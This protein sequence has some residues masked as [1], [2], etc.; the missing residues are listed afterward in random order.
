MEITS[1]LQSMAVSKQP[2]HL[3]SSMHVD[4]IFPASPERRRLS[5]N[6]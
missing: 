4:G 5:V 6:K 2:I 1:K 3:T